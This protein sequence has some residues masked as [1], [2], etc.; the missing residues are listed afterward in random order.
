MTLSKWVRTSVAVFAAAFFSTHAAVA[1]TGVGELRCEFLKNPLGIDARQPRLNWILNSSERGQRQTAY[2]ILVASSEENL[3]ADRG[4]LWDSG[5]VSSDDS[6]QVVYAGKPLASRADAFWKVRV[7][8]RDGK[9]SAWSAPAHWTM[10]LLDASDWHAQWIGLDGKDETNFLAN[11]FWI[12][13]PGGEPEK[14]VPP[15]TNYFRREIFI[16]TNQVVKNIRF[17]YTGDSECRGWINGL[18][19]GARN[20]FRTVK[21]TD[22]THRVT[23]GTNIICLTG[24]SPGPNAKPAGVVALIEIEFMNGER[25]VI[26]TDEQWKVSDREEKSWN[27]LNFDD[28]H[29]V[30]AKKIGPV[31]MQPWGSVRISES[32][33][34]PARYLRKEFSLEKKI[35]RATV[36]FSG[37]GWSELYFNGEKVG[38]AVLSPAATDYAKRVFYV[39]YDVTKLL[40]PGANSVGAILG[41][42]HYYAERSKVYSGTVSY[43]WPKM[44][45][46]LRVDLSDG[47]SDEIISDGSWLLTTNGPIRANNQYDGE[48]YDARMELGDW[49]KPNYSATQ[50]SR[51]QPVKIVSAPAGELV[52]Q[53]DLPIRVTQTL[54]P[55]AV[56]EIKSG[57]FIFDMG[58]NM[59][60]WCRL[61]VS[62][63]AGDSVMLRFAEATNADGSLY[64]ANLRGAKVTDI[65][66]LRGAGRE[67]VWEPRFTYH[68]FRYVEV[69]GF[70]GK[71]T[72]DSLDGHVVNDDLPSA[73]EFET[74]NPLLNKIY[75]AVVWGTRGNYHSFPT[76]CP[77]RDERQGWMGDRSEESRGE[78]YIF[79]N[80]ALYEKWLNDMADA[81]RPSGSVPDVAPPYWPIYSDNVTWPSTTVIVPEM[82]RDQFADSEIIARHYDSANK[83]IEHMS[84]FVSNGLISRDNYGDWCVPPEDPILIHSKD[85]ARITD[86]TLLATSYFYHDLRL[87]EGYAK[88]LGKTDDAQHFAQVADEMKTAFNKKFLDRDRGQYSNGTQ[89]SCVLPLAFDLVPDDMRAKIFACLTNNIENVTHGHIG[90]GL[91][92]GQYLNRV[93]TDNGRADLAYRI[94]SQNDYPSWGYMIEH[95]ATTI[96]ELWNGNTA[97]PAM[98]S[99]NHVMLVG[100]LVIWFY[101]DLAGIAPD[102]AQPGFA[103]IIMNPQPVGDLKFVKAS[104]NSPHGLIKSE[105]HR[106]GKE[107]KW[108][109]TIPANT[110]A[111]IHIPAKAMDDVTESSRPATRAKGVKFLRMENGRA[112]FEIG[113]GE[114][115]FRSTG[116]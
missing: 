18:D 82:L 81:Q 85:P 47:T 116:I 16:P 30:T 67:E 86:K 25:E 53:M 114:Y 23:P 80:A 79:D 20:N 78:S 109:I 22:L 112:V 14:S 39:T 88:M 115:Q 113:S 43:G 11:T 95:G 7:W 104:H 96:W 70:P 50:N 24:R 83:W 64:M 65:Y 72:L 93:L 37:L 68:G 48:E 98:N 107:F 103:R 17:Q 42:G 21:D 60:G 106:D 87:M 102:P 110:T 91:I 15:A 12:W 75:R 33:R 51:W 55:I 108:S 49:T 105:W 100:D 56:N 29:W 52:A 89:T 28:S 57:V 5:K 54:K 44:R 26:P 9:V 74:S 34:Q 73:G 46:Q 63:H 8:D 27:E 111:E 69:T 97:D 31:G 10:G 32:R 4:D 41:N 92:G 6:V 1:S 13:S 84:E 3:R 71:P 2:Q 101:E 38:D 62:G 94:A 45:M 36:Y 61:K 76:D 90:T 59:V 19:L 40:H 66:T 99:G 77:Q 58:Q 35:A